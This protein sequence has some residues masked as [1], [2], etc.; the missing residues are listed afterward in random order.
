MK[1]VVEIKI[2][3]RELE[4]KTFQTVDESGKLDIKEVM[5]ALKDNAQ[6]IYDFLELYLEDYDCD[7]LDFSNL[8]QLG[9][10]I[11]MFG[12]FIEKVK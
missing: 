12:A 1:K 3:K 4:E 2:S 9:D 7:E 8:Y 10:L 6:N 11:N 5:T